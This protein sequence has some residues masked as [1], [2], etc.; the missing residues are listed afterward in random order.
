[1][2]P[3]TPPILVTPIVKQ[4]YSSK[5]FWLGVLLTVLGVATYFADPTHTPTLTLASIS[6]AVGGIGTIVL[7]VW[8]TNSAID[9]TSAASARLEPPT[10]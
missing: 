6:E 3:P 7:R 10:P 8:F 1:M 4:W 2:I 9:G 5:T